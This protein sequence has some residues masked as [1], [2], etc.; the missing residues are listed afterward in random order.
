[1]H[2]KEM[3][4]SITSLTVPSSGWHF[5]A[6]SA[7]GE[8]LTDFRVEELATSMEH[9]ALELCLLLSSLLSPLAQKVSPYIS[10]EPAGD[11]DEDELWAAAKPEGHPNEKELR[12]ED[13]RNQ[14][15][16]AII[17]IVCTAFFHT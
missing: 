8:R 9:N 14:Q 2:T 5:S 6:T 16:G 15:R 13:A 3:V 17:R 11:E 7:S 10:G 4:D 1:M 12:K